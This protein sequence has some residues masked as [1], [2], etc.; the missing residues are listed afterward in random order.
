MPSGVTGSHVVVFADPGNIAGGSTRYYRVG[1]AAVTGTE[2]QVMF[3]QACTIYGIG[4]NCRV[5]P[6]AARTDTWTVRKNGVNTTIT[7]SLVGAA[8]S[9][10]DFAHPLSVAAGDLI[11]IQVVTAVSTQLQDTVCSLYVGN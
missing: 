5:G 10:S 3:H 2:I 1:S 7:T 4:V 6:G 8:T 11:S 9:S